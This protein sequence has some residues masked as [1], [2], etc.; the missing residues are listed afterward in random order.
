MN[1][2]IILTQIS[3]EAPS[4]TFKELTPAYDGLGIQSLTFDGSTVKWSPVITSN[5]VIVDGRIKDTNIYYNDGRVGIGRSPLFTYHFDLAVPKDTRTT[6]FHIGDGS[7]GF[8][9]GNGT[10][11]GFLPE[12]I[13][14]GSDKDDAGLYFVG[15][16]GNDEQSDIPL[17]IIDGRSTYNTQIT[18]RPIFGVTS[19][20]YNKYAI[21]ID[22]SENMNVKG[23]IIAPD[24]ILNKKSLLETINDLQRQINELRT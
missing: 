8:S 18:N 19:G 4:I 14:V 22:A 5:D 24:I 10:N 11:K 20:N 23:T 9:L 1:N 7:F 15:I 3:G 16:A 21:L 6:A 17:V 12:I 2:N 13:G